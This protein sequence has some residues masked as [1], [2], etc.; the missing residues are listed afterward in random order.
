MV[1]DRLAGHRLSLWVCAIDIQKAFDTID[2]DSLWQS[3]ED[4]IVPG[5]YVHAMAA[6]YSEQTGH[7]YGDKQGSEAQHM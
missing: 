4:R 5:G 7:V 3:L 6:I 1:I 2:R